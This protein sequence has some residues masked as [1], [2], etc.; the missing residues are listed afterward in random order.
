[1][2]P[3]PATKPPKN[4]TLATFATRLRTR[5]AELGLSQEEAASRAGIHWTGYSRLERAQAAPGL[6]LTLKI[7]RGL[8]TTPGALL[9]GLPI[10]D[11]AER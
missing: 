6:Y 5:R 8:K 4:A 3:A 11:T 2:S 1:M 9:D 7:A 10:S